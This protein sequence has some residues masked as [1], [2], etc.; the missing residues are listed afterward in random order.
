MGFFDNRIFASF[1]TLFSRVVNNSN[2]TIVGPTTTLTGEFPQDVTFERLYEYYNGWPQIKRSV[3]VEHQKFMGAGIKI[4]SNNE[5]FNDFIKK[6]WEITNADKKWSQF[7]LSTLITGNGLMERQYAPSETSNQ[8]LLANIEQVPMQTIYRIYRDQFGNDLKLVQIVDGIFKE[9][10][11]DF[12]IRLTINNPDRQAFG[13]SEFFSVAA[14]RK[15]TNEVD[16]MTQQPSNPG[17]VMESILDSEAEL[18]DAQT[19]IKKIVAKPKI[20]GSFPGMPQ[21]QLE[22]I[23][24][25]MQDPGNKKYFWAFNKEAK[26]AEAQVSDQGKFDKYQEDLNNL[27][28]LAGGFPEK[29][30]TNPGG[31]SYASSVTPMDV[32]DERMANLRTDGGELI[33]DGLLRPLAK[34]FGFDGF[35]DMDVEVTFLPIVRKL[36][37]EEI[38]QIP[39]EVVPPE[40]KREMLKELQVSLNDELYD[41]AIMK[42]EQQQQ[43]Q[44]DQEQANFDTTNKTNMEKGKPPPSDGPPMLAKPGGG[45]GGDEPEE[46]SPVEKDRPVPQMGGPEYLMRN[47]KAF[48][49]YISKLVEERLEMGKD[50]PTSVPN[51]VNNTTSGRDPNTQPITD[52][53]PSS[54][55]PPTDLVATSPTQT[56]PPKVT[57]PD[58]TDQLNQEMPQDDPRVVPPNNE[59]NPQAELKAAQQPE[60]GPGDVGVFLPDEDGYGGPPDTNVETPDT[61]EASPDMVPGNPYDN[62]PGPEEPQSFDPTLREPTERDD[63]PFASNGVQRGQG[64]G[65]IRDTIVSEPAVQTKP[66]TNMIGVDPERTEEPNDTAWDDVFTNKRAKLLPGQYYWTEDD[67]N[68]EVQDIGDQPPS[69]PGGL[70]PV[71]NGTNDDGVRGLDLTKPDVDGTKSDIAP[72]TKPEGIAVKP[73][74]AP[75]TPNGQ[76]PRKNAKRASQ[77]VM[78]STQEAAPDGD[79]ITMRG[80]HILIKK[81]QS[82]R[83]A[84]NDFLTSKDPEHADKRGSKIQGLLDSMDA[85]TTKKT[86]RYGRLKKE[87]TALQKQGHKK[88]DVKDELK[89]QTDGPKTDAD[90]PSIKEPKKSV[91]LKEPSKAQGDHEKALNDY[92][93]DTKISDNKMKDSQDE[94]TKYKAD[95]KTASRLKKSFTKRDQIWMDG[96]TAGNAKGNGVTGIADLMNRKPKSGDTKYG[97]ASKKVSTGDVRDMIDKL[98]KRELLYTSKNRNNYGMI[99]RGYH[100]SQQYSMMKYGVT[101]PT[102]PT[103]PDK[104]VKRREEISQ[105]KHD[106]LNRLADRYQ[107]A[108]GSDREGSKNKD[109]FEGQLHDKLRSINKNRDFVKDGKYVIDTSY[110]RE[111][112]KDKGVIRLMQPQKYDLRYPEASTHDGYGSE[113]RPGDF[114]VGGKMVKVGDIVSFGDS[115]AST[116]VRVSSFSYDGDE[117]EGPSINGYVTYSSNHSE[118]PILQSKHHGDHRVS[119]VRDIEES[120]NTKMRTPGQR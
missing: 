27:I 1:N 68:P 15:V 113:W 116:R 65:P 35:D 51:S 89:R 83:D 29:I 30:I 63:Q 6:W 99:E 100:S 10:D 80:A 81:G 103:K 39:D 52:E 77:M 34:S 117:W 114:E 79:W 19:E 41:N 98:E 50:Y 66:P 17:R 33:R 74:N 12:Y 110:D 73:T 42:Q 67:E 28:A 88:A 86:S 94:M 48:E 91:F 36:K 101:E 69:F 93:E 54:T 5:Q 72:I 106:Q 37:F 24:K 22:K 11:P 47:P 95:L 60:A 111:A 75:N 108:G 45:F 78:S 56:Q 13:K 26:V 96:I 18:V 109:R 53:P 59:P 38:L 97:F 82:K 70:P 2:A 84:I 21:V 104:P 58:V 62:A 49:G 31:F 3:D 46:R 118:H 87:L 44:Q 120:S 107:R 55:A 25:E 76:D 20:F 71:G 43:Q 85:G 4:T 9:I 8:P 119:D 112:G 90:E 61:V 115:G 7:F 92:A 14:P 32:I 16:P 57:D 64:M 23:E 102:Q 40:E 105:S